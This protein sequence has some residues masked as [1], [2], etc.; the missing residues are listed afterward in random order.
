MQHLNRVHGVGIAFLHE[1]I[2]LDE[3]KDPVILKY[4]ESCRMAADIHTK[5]FV[6]SDKWSRACELINVF[7][8]DKLSA[9]L[10][11]KRA[12]PA[13]SFAV[14]PEPT[15]S[16][17]GNADS[18]CTLANNSKCVYC[19]EAFDSRNGLFKHLR[20]VCLKGLIQ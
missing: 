15:T 16:F 20:Q 19:G 10:G 9:F 8:Q 6:D 11:A 5:A 14:S 13:T 17:V 7:D 1:R 12:T 3:T 2:V 18:S 4:E